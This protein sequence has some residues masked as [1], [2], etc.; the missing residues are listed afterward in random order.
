MNA[1][2]PFSEEI[3]RM[4]NDW[5]LPLTFFPWD[6]CRQNLWTCSYL[7]QESVELEQES[8]ELQESLRPCL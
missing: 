8:V 5:G 6:A 2:L 1:P 3:G 4:V 7:E